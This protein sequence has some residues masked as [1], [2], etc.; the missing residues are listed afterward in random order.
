MRL[1]RTLLLIPQVTLIELCIMFAQ[2]SPILILERNCFVMLMLR[3]NVLFYSLDGLRTHGKR[4]IPTLP[5][6]VSVS[7]M[8]SLDPIR[9]VTFQRFKQFDRG[10]F[11]GEM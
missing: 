1:T 5:I 3:I 8:L 11:L 4:A 2:N 10:N 7:G 9:S 6:K